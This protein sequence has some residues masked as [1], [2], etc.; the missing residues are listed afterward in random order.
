LRSLRA[1]AASSP[2]WRAGTGAAR[3]SPGKKKTGARVLA[4]FSCKYMRHVVC[5]CVYI[6][7]VFQ[8][9]PHCAPWSCMPSLEFVFSCRRIHNYAEPFAC[10]F[11]VALSRR[12]F[13]LRL[14]G[15]LEHVSVVELMH[16]FTASG[17]RCQCREPCDCE[18]RSLL[19]IPR[20]CVT[21]HVVV[22]QIW[23]N[24]CK[25]NAYI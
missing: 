10:A 3:V 7:R 18:E 24:T 17:S 12:A 19:S 1:G 5:S 16:T 15:R 20:P 23:L 9:C 21:A 13:R 2:Y 6:L 25:N 8:S 11:S 4:T 22:H 14:F